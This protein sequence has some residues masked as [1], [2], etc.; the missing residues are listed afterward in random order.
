MDLDRPESEL[1]ASSSP[2]PIDRESLRAE[3]R[4]QPDCVRRL[5]LERVVEQLSDADLARLFGGLT[6]LDR[7]RTE[8][9]RRPLELALEPARA[10]I[11]RH[12]AATLRGEYLGE[13]SLK[14]PHGERAP[15]MTAIWLAATAHLL[16]VALAGARTHPDEE[17]LAGLRELVEM[18][19]E[20]DR[21]PDELV[22]FEDDDSAV[23]FMDGALRKARALL[24][25]KP[26]APVPS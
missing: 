13:I 18:I 4:V 6:R 23:L 11:R 26:R 14:H 20:V 1:D 9:G 17:V 5:A 8:P 22:V 10:R 16:D 19:A 15:K 24:G 12:A 25:G 2:G 3:L 21:R 7:H